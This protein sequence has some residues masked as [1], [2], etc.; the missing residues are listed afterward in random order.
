MHTCVWEAC[1]HTTCLGCSVHMYMC[2][3]AH[4][5]HVSL[6]YTYVPDFC[7]SV[8]AR[9]CIVHT[10]IGVLDICVHV[11]LGGMHACVCMC[12]GFVCKYSGGC[13]YVE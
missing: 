7:A 8:E 3:C 5:A 2:M 13:I 12:L 9:G 10:R 4:I 1:V 6:G 11:S